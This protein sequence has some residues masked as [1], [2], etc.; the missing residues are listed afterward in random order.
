M[1]RIYIFPIFKTLPI[2]SS[3]WWFQS[4]SLLSLLFGQAIELAALL[5]SC[6]TVHL[7]KVSLF[8]ITQFSFHLHIYPVIKAG[9]Q[10]LLPFKPSPLHIRWNDLPSLEVR[11][12][13]YPLISSILFSLLYLNSW[14]SIN[15][16]G[17]HPH[18]SNCPFLG[19]LARIICFSFYIQ[20]LTTECSL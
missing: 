5:A 3:R 2:L 13:L 6:F 1:Y 16:Y 20:V 7:Q 15:T 4:F 11:G 12:D 18:L 19:G 8:T 10:S 14:P 17:A 9:G